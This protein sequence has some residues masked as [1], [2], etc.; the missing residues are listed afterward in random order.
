[1]SIKKRVMFVFGT[2][3]EAI[4]LAPVINEIKK[5]PDVFE[6][7]IV[8]TGQHRHMLDQVLRV[9]DI[10]PDYDMGIMEEGQTIQNV[11]SKVLRGLE[12]IILRE[13]PDIVLVQGD[14]STAFAASLSA[15]YRKVPVGHVEAGLR[16]WDKYRPFPEE[17]NRKL[18]TSLA[19]IHFAPT[20]TSVKNLKNE[21]VPLVSIYL[22]GNTVID[23]LFDVAKKDFDLRRVGLDLT[24][25]KK[26]VLVTTH[27][28]ESF[29]QP[30]KAICSAVRE[31][32]QKH[33]DDAKF[34]IPVH[35]NPSVRDVIFDELS[36]L[37]NVELIE[38]LEYE[39]FVHLMKASYLILTDSG[40]IQEEAPSL[41]KPVMVLREVTERPEGVSAGVVKLVGVK[42]ESIIEA[43]EKLL[44]DRSEYDKM[45]CKKNPYG[46]GL[47]SQRV[48][49]ALLHYFGM[50]DR[51]PLEFSFS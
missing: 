37:K 6:L 13:K 35:K 12:G 42:T 2:R 38:P 9:F 51:R 32:A 21:G 34:V 41:G 27:R 22:T 50:I 26:V 7:L 3:P 17:M 5:H 8:V 43:C 14:T 49:S 1:L 4:K 40:G 30:L 24:A 47:A 29:G 33:L 10:K 28:R 16:T 48:V 20:S 39:P 23:A 11:V 36:G 18:T 46:D 44:C 19:D 31:I 45:A 15:F 25:G